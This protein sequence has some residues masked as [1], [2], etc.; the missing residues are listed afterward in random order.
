M[1]V[2]R[3][4]AVGLVGQGQGLLSALL[5]AGCCMANL[6]RLGMVERPPQV[7]KHTILSK[8]PER[9]STFQQPSP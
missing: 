3:F 8:Y 2:F 6:W 5:L 7:V 1:W 9:A 4:G